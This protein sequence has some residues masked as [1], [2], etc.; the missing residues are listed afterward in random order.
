MLFIIGG[1]IGKKRLPRSR[2]L[3]GMG[4]MGMGLFLVE[5]GLLAMV[6]SL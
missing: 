3:H 6:F 2:C 4:A 1:L 5:A